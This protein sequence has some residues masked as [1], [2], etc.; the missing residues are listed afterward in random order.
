MTHNKPLSH[1]SK[2][3]QTLAWGILIFV[4]IGRKKCRAEIERRRKAKLPFRLQTNVSGVKMWKKN[5]LF[6]AFNKGERCVCA[7]DKAPSNLPCGPDHGD[8]R[9]RIV[10]VFSALDSKARWWKISP[11]WLLSNMDIVF[12]F[13][14]LRTLNK[15]QWLA[16][17]LKSFILRVHEMVIKFIGFPS[18]LIRVC[19]RRD[20]FQESL[21]TLGRLLRRK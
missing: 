15:D 13:V 12:H 5:F 21:H 18:R 2:L 8:V 3:N 9:P 14:S 11:S 1:R 4:C 17:V 16:V 19:V 6:F 20:L 10:F 7:D